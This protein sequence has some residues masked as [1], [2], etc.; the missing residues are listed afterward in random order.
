MFC[1]LV[2]RPTGHQ[3]N[4]SRRILLCAKNRTGKD[5]RKKLQ[6]NFSCFENVHLEIASH[7]VDVWLYER[8][9]ATSEFSEGLRKIYF[10]VIEIARKCRLSIYIYIYKLT[11]CCHVKACLPFARFEAK[12]SVQ[13]AQEDHNQHQY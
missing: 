8:C 10:S 11:F 4:P 12:Q 7:C 13:I 1:R 5:S 9:F 6:M 2:L 3:R